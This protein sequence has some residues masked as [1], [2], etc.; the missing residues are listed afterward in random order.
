MDPGFASAQVVSF[1]ANPYLVGY[2][3]AQGT[4]LRLALTERVRQIP[5]VDAV[6]AA[7]R[8]LMRVSGVKMTIGSADQRVIKDDFLNT[9]FNDVTPEYF[10]TVG[11]HI[12]AGRNLRDAD[13]NNPKP[14]PVV[15]NQAFVRRFFPEG[16]PMGRPFSSGTAGVGI[17]F[18]VVGVVNDAHYRSL[19]EP[20]PPTFYEL[21]TSGNFIL[22][23][24]THRRPESL[25]QPV[26][27]AFTA[28]DP[29][30]PFTEV[31]TL[32][33]EVD[34]SAAPERLTAILASIFGLFAALLAAVVLYG[35]LA[36]AVAQ[37]QREIGI[38]MALGALPRGIARL[39]GG[40][41]LV[42][43]AVG[44]VLGL[45]AAFLLAPLAGTVLY[46]VGPADPL[47]MAAAAVLVTLVASLAAL[48]PAARAARVDPAVALRD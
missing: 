39:I 34:D 15:A 21:Q 42:L 3:D 46:G 18:Q 33:E 48:I 29:A 30:L 17:N 4:A 14:V 11:M 1:T 41:A 16:N 23:V 2:S 25:I 32:A 44:V 27:Q 36:Y 24:R 35:L 47:S 19:R 13:A 6:A 28:L 43:V 31:H 10:E 7:S 38:R 9:S 22:Y 40:Q 12:L 8:P 20:V 37:R 5:G 26:R 45:V